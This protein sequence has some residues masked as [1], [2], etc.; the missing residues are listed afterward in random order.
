MRSESTS[1]SNDSRVH[2]AL[3]AQPC[4]GD[5]MQR[6]DIETVEKI[7]GPDLVVHATITSIE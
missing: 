4:L 3:D 5:A 6:V 1:L 7:F 2:A